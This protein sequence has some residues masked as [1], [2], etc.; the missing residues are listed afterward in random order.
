MR[1]AVPWP[2]HLRSEHG[3]VTYD[4]LLQYIQH[5]M[6]MQHIYQPV[7]IEALLDANGTATLRQG[8]SSPG[9]ATSSCARSTPAPPAS[10]SARNSPRDC[11]PACTPA[12]SPRSPGSAAPCA[13]GAPRSWP[14]STPTASATAAPKRSTCSSRRPAASPTA[15]A[16]S[17]TTAYGCCWRPAAPAPAGRPDDAQIRR[18]VNPR[19]REGSG[20]ASP[21]ATASACTST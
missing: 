6:S 13:P 17:P 7:V 16:T 5:E 12:R 18:A 15:T 8:S 21:A 14:T 3:S 11:S 1:A 4:E 20:C 9:P 10:A 2:G 19:Q